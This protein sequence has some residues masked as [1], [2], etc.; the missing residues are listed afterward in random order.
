[1]KNFREFINEINV[2]SAGGVFGTGGSFGHGGSVGNSD[3][4]APGDARL[5][6]ALGTFRRPG[7]SGKRKKQRKIKRAI[8][9]KSKR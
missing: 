1:M 6:K 7:I 5:P 4:Y 9:R 3:F 8:K 2:A